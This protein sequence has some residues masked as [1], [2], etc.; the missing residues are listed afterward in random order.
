MDLMHTYTHLHKSFICFYQAYMKINPSHGILC[1]LLA[2][3]LLFP[4]FCSKD[5]WLSSLLSATK[6]LPHFLFDTRLFPPACSDSVI[7]S[8]LAQPSTFLVCLSFIVENNGEETLQG[9]TPDYF[10]TRRVLID[11]TDLS[12]HGAI[13]RRLFVPCLSQ[14][15][16]SLPPF[17]SLFQLFVVC[18][19]LF[20]CL[21]HLFVTLQLRHAFDEHCALHESPALIEPY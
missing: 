5:S 17:L 21:S 14:Q 13:D 1:S 11:Q 18:P 8:N 3:L 16:L 10:P 2:P 12:V 4:I 19:C 20:T 6:E 9:F 7:H 15:S